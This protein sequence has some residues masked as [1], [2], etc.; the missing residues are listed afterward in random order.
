MIVNNSAHINNNCLYVQFYTMNRYMQLHLLSYSRYI[1]VYILLHNVIVINV[2]NNMYYLCIDMIV[3]NS[4]H[5]NNDSNPPGGARPGARQR[6][7]GGPGAGGRGIYIYIYIYDMYTYIY[8][9][10]HIH[11]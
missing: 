7:A 1:L 11:M 5:I 3:N 6:G 9:Y 10:I 8:T 4:A 2:M